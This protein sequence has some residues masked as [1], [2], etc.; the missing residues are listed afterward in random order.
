MHQYSTTSISLSLLAKLGK[1]LPRNLKHDPKIHSSLNVYFQIRL[2]F[3]PTTLT[4]INYFGYKFPIYL[5]TQ[6]YNVPYTV[7]LL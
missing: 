2:I 5:Y 7:H 1:L 3:S 6:L 4:S